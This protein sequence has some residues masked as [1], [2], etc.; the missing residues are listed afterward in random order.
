MVQFTFDIIYACDK[1]NGIGK[2]NAIPWN[3]QEDMKYFKQIT[4]FKDFYGKQNIVIM[5]LNTWKSIGGPLKD[6]IN[7]I[8]S[9][10]YVHEDFISYSS[11]THVVIV[12][13][14]FDAAKKYIIDNYTLSDINVYVIG[15]AMLYNYAITRRECRYVY[16]TNINEDYKCTIQFILPISSLELINYSKNIFWCSKKLGMTTVEF[17]KY[18]NV[19]F[20]IQYLNIMENILLNGI[21]KDARNNGNETVSMFSELMTFNLRTG[22]PLL[23]TKRVFMR[24]VF[25][26]LK[27]F[28]T[29]QTNT[30]LL[31]EKGIKIWSG[32]TSREFLDSVDL[33]HYSEGDLGTSYSFVLKHYG[34]K[35]EG[36]D[37]DYTGQ[38]IDQFTELLKSIQRN[39]FSRRLLMTTY[40]PSVLSQGPLPPCHGLIIQ[41]SVNN[42]DIIDCHMY[43]RS[44]DWVLGV[45]F[46]IASYA[47]MTHIIA[48]ILH[49]GVGTLTMSFGD[50]HIYKD[51]ISAVHKVLNRTLYNPCTLNIKKDI[52]RIDDLMWED[53]EILNYKCHNNDLDAKMVA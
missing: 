35:Y 45:P 18:R 41:F 24:G 7:I 50:I 19:H 47:L 33:H 28:L 25:E 14:S 37:K 42:E 48:K 4:T 29:G 31:E 43:Q 11:E 39:K 32:N 44:A 2:D 36:M 12:L 17:K 34:A 26:E 10:S 1:E 21:I 20:E 49:L 16:A 23:T 22:F 38:G 13:E 46:N 5:G 15:G 27:F 53:I 30:K 8:I 6:R 52:S 51:H 9:S 40:N 3:I